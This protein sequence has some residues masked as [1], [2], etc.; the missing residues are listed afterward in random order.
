MATFFIRNFGCR[1]T[2]ADADAIRENLLASGHTPAESESSAAIVILNTCT[3]TAAADAEARESIRRIH[4]ENPAARIIATGCYAQRAPEEVASLAGV[5]S[6]VGN[7]HQHELASQLSR[8]S[9]FFPASALLRATTAPVFREEMLGRTVPINFQPH[10]HTSE[11]NERTRPT[12]KIQDGCNHR[13][14]YCVIPL[15]RG[16]SRSAEPALVIA[17]INR[18]VEAGVQE[19]VLSGIDLGNYGRDLHPRIS[20]QSLVRKIISETQLASLR[21]SSIEPIDITQDFIAFVASEPRVAPHFHMPLQSGCDKILRAMH[22]WYRAEHYARRVQI[23]RELLPHAAIGADVIAGFPG[24]TDEDHAA[25]VRFLSGLPLSYLHVFSF[26]P[27]TGTEAATLAQ[28]VPPRI[29]RA[30]AHELRAIARKKSEE[31]H[32][33]QVGRQFRALTLNRRQGDSTF[34]VTGNYLNIRVAGSFP[35]NRWLEILVPA[36]GASA[37]PLAS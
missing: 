32:S 8:S 26:S 24:E 35:R 17:E 2:Q 18:L 22:R 6:V 23:I 31:F 7:S 1:A 11:T 3:V 36:D 16:R 10:L 5:F 15:V 33:S 21:L 9:E 19:I 29:I 27:R 4:R 30:R 20:L 34:A 37:V 12:L 25:T 14:A 28:A 13:C